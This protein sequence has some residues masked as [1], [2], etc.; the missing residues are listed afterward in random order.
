MDFPAALIKSC[1]HIAVRHNRNQ[2]KK[3]GEGSYHIKGKCRRRIIKDLRLSDHGIQKPEPEQTADQ[4]NDLKNRTGFFLKD[5]LR[6]VYFFDGGTIG[7]I[8]GKPEC[9]TAHKNKSSRLCA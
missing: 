4:H 9:K 3:S 2:K 8:S 7:I 6:I 5:Q 1:D